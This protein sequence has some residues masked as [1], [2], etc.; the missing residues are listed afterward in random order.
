MDLREMRQKYIDD[1]YEPL[2][3]SSK[4]C[5]DILLAKISKSSLNRNITIKGGVVMHNISK[6]NRRA[7]RDL[8]QHIMKHHPGDFE[9][10]NRYISEI[11]DIPDVIV[12]DNK[13]VDTLVFIKRIHEENINIYM[14][15]KLST[16]LLQVNKKNTIL[17]LWKI[18]EKK[19]NQIIRNK[20]IIWKKLDKYE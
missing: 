16:N 9:K 20:E 10:Y 4:V 2:D 18:K 15:I 1:G 5:Q 8:V 7:T 6:D 11:L 12:A 14:V 19:C 17:T 13:N 3:A